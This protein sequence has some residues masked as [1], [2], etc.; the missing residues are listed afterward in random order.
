MVTPEEPLDFDLQAGG[1]AMELTEVLARYMLIDL[2]M[3]PLDFWRRELI[4]LMRLRVL[5][6]Y[7]A[8]LEVA[9]SHLRELIG[10]R[11]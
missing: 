5:S 6:L 7:G 1:P 8:E 4:L 2:P 10:G 9:V 3:D 11:P